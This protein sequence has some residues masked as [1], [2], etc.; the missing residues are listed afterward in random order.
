MSQ[1][2]SEVGRS[3]A[4]LPRDLGIAQPY[5][6]LC[7]ATM[8]H[9]APKIVYTYRDSPEDWRKAIGER[10]MFQFGVYDDPRSR[11]PISLDESGLRYFDQQMEI[12]GF[13]R[14][15]HG[16][17]RIR[18]I[19]D[20]GCGWGFGLK[21]LADHFP[22][23]P[24][25]DGINISPAQLEYC[26]KYHREQHLDDRINL[27]LCDAQDVDL[28]PDADDPYDL[29]TIR[30]VISHFP[31]DLYER[32][33]AKLAARVQPGTKV[34]ISDNLYN[35]PLDVYQ[36]DTEDEVD[37]LAC[38]HR[39][40]PDYFRRVIEQNGFEVE[41]MRV[42]PENID[43]ARWFMDVKKNIE[44]NFTEDNIPPPLEELRV[45]AVNVSVALIKNLFSTYSVIARRTTH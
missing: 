12:A 22:K 43:V 16:S 37:R 25:L 28:L 31:N 29:V 20:V 34:I 42:L 7:G 4:G 19:L 11:P 8:N 1:V 3:D 21:Y 39:K 24:R 44:T 17:S 18:R 41:D 26:A 14:H 32:A 27:Y 23:C 9:Y 10:L 13:G 36:S 40:T 38:K 2:I 30:G 33:M 5:R 35:V 45:M 6:V 15:G